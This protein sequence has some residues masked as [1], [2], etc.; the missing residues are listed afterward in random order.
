MGKV[1]RNEGIDRRTHRNTLLEAYEAY[2]DYDSAAETDRRS[3]WTPRKARSTTPVSQNGEQIDL[4]GEWRSVRRHDGVAEALGEQISPDTY[5]ELAACRE[6][7]RAL[8]PGL[9]A[10]L[11]SS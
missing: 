9:T 8:A 6:A 4:L 2:G 10:Q 3:L 7:L 5:R 11:R 1:F